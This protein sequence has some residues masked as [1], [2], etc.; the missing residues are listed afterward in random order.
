MIMKTPFISTKN[1][2]STPPHTQKGIVGITPTLFNS[3]M[4]Y[5]ITNRA[6]E[7]IKEL[8]RS[9]WV[10]KYNVLASDW[11]D[12]QE[13]GINAVLDEMDDTMEKIVDIYVGMEE[14]TGEMPESEEGQVDELHFWNVHSDGV[15]KK[16]KLS[17]DITQF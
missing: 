16:N 11:T 7:L 17:A 1:K 15:E 14:V 12:G 6:T 8:K 3:K 5:T 9:D 4:A 13:E 10:P 2:C